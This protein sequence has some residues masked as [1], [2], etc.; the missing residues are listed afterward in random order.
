MI[1]ASKRI[2]RY[3]LWLPAIIVGVVLIPAMFLEAQW[4]GSFALNLNIQSAMPIDEDSLRFAT[5]A[6]LAE[7]KPFLNFARWTNDEFDAADS[8]EP[9]SLFITTYGTS[10]YFR[11]TY[12]YKEHFIVEYLNPATGQKTRQAFVI[13][14]GRGDRTMTLVLRTLGRE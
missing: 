8:F 6:T 10:G 5:V 7:T 11:D 12:I 9:L 14:P 4:I 2:R 1:K 13:P 3:W